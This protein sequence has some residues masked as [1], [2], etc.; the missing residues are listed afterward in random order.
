[1][2]EK[3][4]EAC[5][6]PS[7]N[8]EGVAQQ[9]FGGQTAKR[10]ASFG[11]DASLGFGLLEA[12]SFALQSKLPQRIVDWRV[13]HQSWHQHGHETG[14]QHRQKHCDVCRHLDDKDDAGQRGA[15][16][17]SEKGGHPDNG[18]S[19]RLNVQ[20]WK[21]KLA[22]LTE[23]QSQLG[24]QY[25]HGSK[26]APR[27]PRRIR[28]GAEPEPEQENERKQAKRTRPDQSALRNRIAAAYKVGHEPSEH[29]ACPAD[30]T[31]THLDGPPVESIDRRNGS[32]Q[33]AI[34]GNRRKSGDRT[35]DKVERL[36]CGT[37]VS[38]RSNVEVCRVAEEHTRH[39]DGC[40][41]RAKRRYRN[42]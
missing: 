20:I 40:R 5:H 41:R 8:R 28:D 7:A 3:G 32:E 29:P 15:D 9:S 13:V 25:K 17:T 31:R 12:C 33:Q 35:E 16:D 42:A 23:E 2:D 22:E 4:I 36:G 30:S 11:F 21:Y 27:C 6:R 38:Q 34:V 37:S 26:Q 18:E 1:M 14:P 39:G 24:S 19:F 10:S